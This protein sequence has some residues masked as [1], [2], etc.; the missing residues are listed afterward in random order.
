MFVTHHCFIC[1]LNLS[2]SIFLL[3]HAPT[4]L[5]AKVCVKKCVHSLRQS[6]EVETV[7][8]WKREHSNQALQGMHL[9]FSAALFFSRVHWF[10]N[11]WSIWVSI[12]AQ[13]GRHLGIIL[14]IRT[15]KHNK[16][17]PTWTWVGTPLELWGVRGEHGVKP[18]CL[19]RYLSVHGVCL[20]LNLHC[21]YV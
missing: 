10:S 9:S 1:F 21:F 3:P 2:P 16:I 4:G 11:I 18:F 5:I 14:T 8:P 19:L 20:L 17:N 6:G 7:I 13:Y 12:L 15:L